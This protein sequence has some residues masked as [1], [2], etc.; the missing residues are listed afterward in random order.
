MTE[1]EHDWLFALLNAVGEN[2]SKLNDWEK[3]FMTDQQSRYEEYGENMRV[4]PKQWAVMNK[5]AEKVG[6]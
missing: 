5:I 4:S 3:G 2:S 6:I 1:E